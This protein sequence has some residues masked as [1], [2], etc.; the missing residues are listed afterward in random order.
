[1][2]TEQNYVGRGNYASPSPS[3]A[4]KSQLTA[5][6]GPQS[7][8]MPDDWGDDF[9]LYVGEDSQRKNSLF[10]LLDVIRSE[11][12]A[13]DPIPTLVHLLNH[14]TMSSYV[15]LEAKENRLKVQRITSLIIFFAQLREAYDEFYGNTDYDGYVNEKEV[16]HE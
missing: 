12:W 10:G 4:I 14:W 1:M 3:T 2:N 5:K 15:R 16:S 9:L 6:N 11:A 7:S 13:D 8:P